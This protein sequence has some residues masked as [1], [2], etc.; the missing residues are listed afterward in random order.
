MSEIDQLLKSINCT[1]P[2]EGPAT[3]PGGVSGLEEGPATGPGGVSGLEEGPDTGPDGVSGLE[4]AG[5]SVGVKLGVLIVGFIWPTFA[6][7]TELVC[8]A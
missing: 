3:G 8:I 6:D 2:E 4:R 5:D 1:A 7:G